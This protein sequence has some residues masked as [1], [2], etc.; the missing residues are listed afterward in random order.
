MF[1]IRAIHDDIHPAN[2]QALEQ[3][4]DILREQFPGLTEEEIAD[5][6]EHLLNPFAK[7][8]KNILY[9]SE[10]R[11]GT[12][13]GFAILM[14]DPTVP[15]CYL[16]F[17]A[18]ASGLTSRG[19][20]GALYDHIR[21]EARELDAKGL[22][23]EC[24]PDDPDA[25]STPELAA[26][27]AARLRFY[28][29]WSA[30]PIVDTEY[31]LPLTPSGKDMPHL[32]YDDLD[33]RQPLSAA[34]A[35]RVIRAILERKYADLY[36][37]QYVERV[38][39][40]IST[41]PVPIRPARYVKTARPRPLKDNKI[42]LVVNESHDIHHVRDRGY[43]E[44]PVRVRALLR[45]LEPTGV[46]Q[47]EEA[48]KYPDRHITEVH[49][50]DFVRFL[51]RAC[52]GVPETRSV[53]PYVFPIRNASRPPKDLAVQAGYYCIDTFT[54]LNANAYLAAR[55]AV[56]CSLTAAE[57][58]VHGSRFAYALVRPPGHHAERR[59]FGGFCYFNNNAIAAQRLSA[60]G[61]VAIL[62]VDYHHGNG[63]Q[64]IF[65]DRSDVLTVS[66]HGHPSFAYPYF[67]GFEEE[68]GNGAGEGFN[69]NLPLPEARTGS[70][71][72]RALNRAIKRI[73]EFKPD[74]LVVALGLDTARGDPTGT[75][76][77]RANDF[78][79]NGRM[80]AAL[81]LPTLVVQE[82]GYRTRSLGVN[83][84]RFFTGLL[85]R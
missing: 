53:Y 65:Y 3:V 45:E 33:R 74:F 5:V 83:A 61:R 47:R 49:D 82:G 40:S 54:P 35:R 73:A 23:F 78:E 57:F 77:L 8:F 42:R 24:A 76:G 66:I 11:G 64:Q 51:K 29:H 20:G 28:E 71:Y 68:R 27:N 39:K 15:F 32:V 63:Q 7:R 36:P 70:E 67:S 12:V 10:G 22:F 4:Q 37:P 21:D 14:N 48:R 13:K 46:F 2:R 1:R 31:E 44:A 30:R 84:R 55:H 34:T 17:I 60:L 18:A 16:D 69:F 58:L 85:S 52:A 6:R 62:D 81:R 59:V 19:I 72:R 56:D 50:A 79:E 75:W 41:D 26:Q 38:L 80:I 25:C 43:V 9:V